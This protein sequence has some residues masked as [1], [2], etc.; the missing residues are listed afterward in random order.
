MENKYT[1]LILVCAVIAMFILLGLYQED[2]VCIDEKCVKVEVAKT[3]A[4]RARGLMFRESLPE[5]E[6]MLFVFPEENIYSFWM[7]NTLI[8]LEIIWIDE[9]FK[10]V[11]IQKA[12]PCLEDECQSYIPTEES[13]YVL[14]VNS[15]FSEDNKIKVGDEVNIN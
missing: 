4:E 6:G 1:K 9:N 3:P 5:N 12:V 7:K 11:D 13:R 8:P 10:V 14:E 15:N 2:R